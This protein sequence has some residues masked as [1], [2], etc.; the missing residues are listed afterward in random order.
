M[1]VFFALTLSMDALGVGVA[2]CLRDRRPNFLTYAIIFFVSLLVM[3]FSV[4]FGNILFGLFSPQLAETVG[5]VWIMLLGLWIIAGSVRKSGDIVKSSAKITVPQ[6]FALAMMLSVD[7]MG[8]GLAAAALGLDIVFLPFLVAA[9]QVT[10]LSLGVFVA[11]LLP[12]KKKGSKLPTMVSGVILVIIG[13][14]SLV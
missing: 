10:C 13:I 1:A 5:A 9:F 6:S 11:D 14:I 7:S 2:C 4:F 12:I 3:G 8:A